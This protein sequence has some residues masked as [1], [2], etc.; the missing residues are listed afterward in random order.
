MT[1]S[2]DCGQ[3]ATSERREGRGLRGSTIGSGGVLL[4]ICSCL[5]VCVR[6]GRFGWREGLAGV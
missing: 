5:F 2:T 3:P 4:C 6:G 1:H